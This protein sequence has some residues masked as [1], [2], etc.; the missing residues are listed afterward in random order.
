MIDTMADLEKYSPNLVDGGVA[1]WT[2]HYTSPRRSLSER[3]ME[4]TIKAQVLGVKVHA[5]IEKDGQDAVRTNSK[6]E[7]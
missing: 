7:L 3:N 5:T 1:G 4:F 6:D 2:T